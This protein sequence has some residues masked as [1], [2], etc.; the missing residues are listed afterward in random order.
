ME[1]GK[2]CNNMDVSGEQTLPAHIDASNRSRVNIST[3]PPPRL[4][5]L[6]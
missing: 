4:E 2:T 1:K 3:P 6:S 5:K